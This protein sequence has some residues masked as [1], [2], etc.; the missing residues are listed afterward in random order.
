MKSVTHYEPEE[1]KSEDIMGIFDS[2]IPEVLGE[3]ESNNLRLE[4]VFERS[5]GLIVT[6]EMVEI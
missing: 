6:L 5:G 3:D 1:W 2:L 4:L